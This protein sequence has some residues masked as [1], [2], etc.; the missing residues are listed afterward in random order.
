MKSV[1][2]YTAKQ[3]RAAIL[4]ILAVFWAGFALGLA[5]AGILF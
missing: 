2:T 1:Y 4:I 3:S 5:T